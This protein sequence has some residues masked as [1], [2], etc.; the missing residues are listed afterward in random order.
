M[1]PLPL[2]PAWRQRDSFIEKVNVVITFMAYIREVPDSNLGRV[3]LPALTEILLLLL[4]VSIRIPG[5][6]TAHF[7]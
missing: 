3:I 6:S 7:I 5:L 1:L 2:A 4:S